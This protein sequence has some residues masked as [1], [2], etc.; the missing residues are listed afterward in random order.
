MNKEQF[1]MAS[2]GCT[3]TSGVQITFDFVKIIIEYLKKNIL[4]SNFM[5]FNLLTAILQ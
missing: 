1:Y 4:F 2:D 5:Y 3:C